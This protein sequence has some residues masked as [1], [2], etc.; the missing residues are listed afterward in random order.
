[1][2]VSPRRERTRWFVRGGL[3]VWFLAALGASLSGVLART[4]GS[5]LPVLPL[6]V[7]A[8]IVVFLLWYASSAA[9]R[10]FVLSFDVGR[11]VLVQTTRVIGGVFLVQYALGALPGTFA[12]PAGLG[13]VRGGAPAPLPAPPARRGPAPSWAGDSW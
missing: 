8:P 9:F 12:L 3:L 1:M 11:M 6:A 2:A 4:R 5:Q 7:L 10:R 13:G